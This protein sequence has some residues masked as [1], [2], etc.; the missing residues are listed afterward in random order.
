MSAVACTSCVA[1][2]GGVPALNA[3]RARAVVKASPYGAS[4]LRARVQVST[5]GRR[6]VKV[7]AEGP[8]ITRKSEPE[9]YWT[10]ES[11]KEGKSPLED[12]MAIA[13]ISGILVPFLIL[14]VAIATGYVELNN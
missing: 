1:L 8:K 6:I 13:A 12:P 5:P 2:V 11:E 10:S 7:R 4:A 14:G 3:R 9:E